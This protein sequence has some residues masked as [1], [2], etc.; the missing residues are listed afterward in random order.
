MARDCRLE[1]LI[2][3]GS[4]GFELREVASATAYL[5]FRPQRIADDEWELA[6]VARGEMG[7]GT[8]VLKNC[9]TDRYLYLSEHEQYIW[10][11]MN[12]RASV[13]DIAAS[14][15]LRF[16]SL[17]FDVI[18]ALIAKLQGADL[19]T[20]RLASR[21]REVLAR[22]PANRGVRP[23]ELAL[24]AL[25]RMT[26][27]S[28]D[29]HERFVSAYR[30]GGRLLFGVPAVAALTVLA[31]FG[32]VAASELAR[33]AHAVAVPLARHPILALLAGKALVF[34]TMAAHQVVHGLACVHYGRRVRAFGF[35]LL[36]GFLPSFFVDVTDIFMTSR[37]ARVVTAIAGPLVHLALGALFFLVAFY[38]PGGFLQAFVAASATLQLYALLFSLY[39]FCFMEMDGYHI[40]V[41]LLGM[42]TLARDSWRFVRFRLAGRLRQRRPLS[43]TESIWTGYV[44]LS[45]LSVAFFVVAT[46]VWLVDVIV[47]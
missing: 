22:H 5:Q 4:G 7:H 15:V 24:R 45:F 27:A 3:G 37:R 14:Y 40:I 28:R 26:L 35:T 30:L 43:R 16:E 29:V 38:L 13:R 33:V 34:A 19:L 31:A 32:L 21:L 11:L 39:P 9:R 18:P 8:F 25:E 44:A 12:G 42:P 47:G 36:H 2:R 20:L 17:D 10:Q 41:D 46:A 1:L 23:L 6:E